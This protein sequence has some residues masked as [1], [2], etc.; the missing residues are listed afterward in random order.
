M[1]TDGFQVQYTWV[2]RLN[3]SIL[4]VCIFFG[5]IPEEK[6]EINPDEYAVIIGLSIVIGITRT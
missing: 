3:N 1:H 2:S 4:L 6:N 5:S